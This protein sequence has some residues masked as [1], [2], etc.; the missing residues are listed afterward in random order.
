MRLVGNLF[1]PIHNPQQLRETVWLYVVS[2]NNVD[3]LHFLKKR[4]SVPTVLVAGQ[5]KNIGR[6]SSTVNRL[7]LRRK[8]FY[9]WQFPG[10]WW[11]LWHREGKTAWRFFDLIFAAVGYYEVYRRALRHYRPHA[12]IF[13][14]DHNDDAR[15][16]LL[17]CQAEGIPTAY[18][19]H[20]SVSRWFPPL[21]FN[22]NLL[23]GQHALD[24]YRMCGPISGQIELVGMPKADS[25]LRH[26][27]QNPVVKRVGLA[28]SLLDPTDALVETLDM[29]THHLPELEFTFR[30]H[31]S[32][33]RN[34]YSLLGKRYPQLRFSNAREESVFEFL[35]SQD[36]MIAAET[37]THLEATL[38][39]LCSIYF[40]FGPGHTHSH[41]YYGFVR[42]NVVDAVDSATA[43]VEKLSLYATA[44]PLD[45]YHRAAYYC[46]TLSTANEGKSEE[47]VTKILE[48]WLAE[49]Y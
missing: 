15:A 19:Q 16:L 24:T 12:V 49:S 45:L 5:G 34:L 48:S 25:F 17:A 3:A 22:L 26:R 4:L 23:E 28:A 31:P 8:L 37:S 40:R 18:L 47:L 6:Y 35:L 1:R 39:N 33:S 11:Q 21:A 29:L 32:D 20:A 36:A 2:Q 7:S 10:I 13:A 14:N 44:K 38:L 43:L 9:Y 27:N 41:D 30:A 46:A 42:H